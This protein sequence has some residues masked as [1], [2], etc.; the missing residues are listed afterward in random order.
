MSRKK[1]KKGPADEIG[2]G[3]PFKNNAA[4][5]NRRDVGQECG[6]LSAQK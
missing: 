1:S 3:D 2:K 6:Q 5:E 4:A